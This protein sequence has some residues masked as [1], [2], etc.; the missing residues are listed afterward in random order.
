MKQLF[1][2]II[3]IELIYDFLFLQ[4][5]EYAVCLQCVDAL[6]SSDFVC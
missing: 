2:C 6:L 4:A 1:T 5:C 3:N